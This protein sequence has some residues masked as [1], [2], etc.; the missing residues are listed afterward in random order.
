[1]SL[2][3]IE[4]AARSTINIQI[5]PNTVLCADAAMWK[6]ENRQPRTPLTDDSTSHTL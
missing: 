6:E 2:W 3:Y 4:R 5:M 1:M